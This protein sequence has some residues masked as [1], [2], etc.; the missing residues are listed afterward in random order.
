MKETIMLRNVINKFGIYAML[1]A[2]VILFSSCDNSTSP[3]TP[4]ET[5]KD[6][7]YGKWKIYS[8]LV[9]LSDTNYFFYKDIKVGNI[10]TLNWNISRTNSKDSIDVNGSSCYGKWMSSETYDFSHW[11]IKWDERRSF[12]NRTGNDVY[13]SDTNIVDIIGV[14]PFKATKIINSKDITTMEEKLIAKYEI[15]GIKISD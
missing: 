3:T 8:T 2:F 10:D 5:L 12:H 15:T 4:K 13:T 7:I 11:E 9:Y 6:N 1:S 14:N